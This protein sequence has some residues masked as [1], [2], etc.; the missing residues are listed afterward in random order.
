[1]PCKSLG[2]PVEIQS[3]LPKQLWDRITKMRRRYT[4]RAETGEIMLS[5]PQLERRIRSEI[6]HSIDNGA[7]L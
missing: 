6:T 1:M 7:I 3:N 2:T 4:S 5:P